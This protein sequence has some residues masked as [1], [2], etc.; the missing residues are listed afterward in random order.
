MEAIFKVSENVTIKW[1]DTRCHGRRRLSDWT[2]DYVF[3]QARAAE[4]SDHDHHSCRDRRSSRGGSKT[5][6]FVPRWG[7]GPLGSELR[8]QEV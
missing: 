7:K 2:G 8:I 6:A 4:L 3:L 1:K 5:E